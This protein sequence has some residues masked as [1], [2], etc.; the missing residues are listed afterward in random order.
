MLN[1]GASFC[2]S[3]GARVGGE[4]MPPVP[5]KPYYSPSPKSLGLGIF[6]TFLINGSGQMYVGRVARGLA[7]F[8]CNCILTASIILLVWNN[9]YIEQGRVYDLSGILGTITVISIIA[10]VLFVWSLYDTYMLIKTYNEHMKNNNG[11]PPW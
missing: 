5:K 6:L 8:G 3:C 10:F 11:N 7:V 2:E 4:V 9:S 1:E